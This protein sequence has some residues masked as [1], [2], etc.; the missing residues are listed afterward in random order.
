[1]NVLLLSQVDFEEF[2]RWWRQ[3]HIAPVQG[4]DV[5]RRVCEKLE[6]KSK[7]LPVQPQTRVLLCAA[8]SSRWEEKGPENP[9]QNDSRRRS[10]FRKFDENSDGPSCIP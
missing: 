3:G 5:F 2:A 6:T 9:A 1:M 8:S 10:V 7:N 4:T